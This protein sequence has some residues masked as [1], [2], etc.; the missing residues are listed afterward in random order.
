MAASGGHFGRRNLNDLLV[1]AEA[2]FNVDL[3]SDRLAVLHGGFEAPVLDGFNRLLIKTHAEIAGYA[4]VARLAVRPDDQP[5]DASSLVLRFTRFFRVF[6]IGRINTARGRNSTTHTEYSATRATATALANAW[7][8]TNTDPA[9]GTR[10][11]PA[12][13]A[14]SV[15]RRPGGQMRHWIT[16]IRQVVH[17]NLHLRRNR[18]GR[19]CNQ[20]GMVITHNH[21]RRSER[22]HVELGKFA[23][24]CLEFVAVS[25]TTAATGL[26]FS[27]LQ[28]G[29]VVSGYVG[30]DLRWFSYLLHDV[31]R[32][33]GDADERS[34]CHD[35]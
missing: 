33:H 26:R 16:Q 9:A 30:D 23:L 31:P 25:A 13:R 32:D 6:R 21:R 27:W 17:R 2:H 28:S 5:Q 22:L 18:Y 19:L 1:E 15:R 34:D 12:T 11:N 24:R 3:N 4:N 7:A 35:M 14:S 8:R 20:L 10:A 29:N